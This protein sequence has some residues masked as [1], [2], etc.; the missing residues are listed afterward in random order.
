MDNKYKSS[1]I[2]TSEELEYEFRITNTNRK[3]ELQLLSNLN[4]REIIF[5]NPKKR[6]TST[7]LLVEYRNLIKIT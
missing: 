1:F 7:N 3:T 6:N 4:D 5:K 2:K